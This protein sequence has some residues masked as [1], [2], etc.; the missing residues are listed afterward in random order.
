MENY[1]LHE[2][3]PTRIFPENWSVVRAEN[4]RRYEFFGNWKFIFLNFQTANIHCSS[5]LRCFRKAPAPIP[6]GLFRTASSTPVRISS[7]YIWS[8]T[9]YARDASP[10]GKV[11]FLFAYEFLTVNYRTTFACIELSDLSPTD[12]SLDS[13]RR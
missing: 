6:R 13:T 2:P 11:F 9:R 3:Y 10:Y 1:I 12:F 4:D 7:P 5:R 8:F